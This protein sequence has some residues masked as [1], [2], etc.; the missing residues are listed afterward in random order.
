MAKKKM[1]GV[2]LDYTK[3]FNEM[4]NDLR[5]S[6]RDQKIDYYKDFYKSIAKAADARLLALERLSSKE[7]YEHVRE[8]AYKLAMHDIHES[9]GPQAKRFNRKIPDDLTKIYKRIRDVLNFLE[10]PTS[11]KQGIDEIYQKRADTIYKRYGIKTDWQT[12]AGLFESKVYQKT[13]SKYGSKTALKAL[14]FIQRNTDT[15]LKALQE[16]KSISVRLG[17]KFDVTDDTKKHVEILS[18]EDYDSEVERRINNYLQYYKKDINS[19]FRGF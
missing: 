6:P 7:N 16:G 4:Q 2:R 15:I 5:G 11:S 9:F 12:I 18:S 10:A 1:V 14:G 3:Q 8:W 19:L 13:D 17:A